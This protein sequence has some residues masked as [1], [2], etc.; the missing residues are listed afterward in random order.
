MG[1]GVRLVGILLVMGSWGWGRWDWFGWGGGREREW[2][3]GDG[4]SCWL[5]GGF[6]LFE[7]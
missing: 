6:F 7:S 4:A 5:G 1:I 2:G 3:M